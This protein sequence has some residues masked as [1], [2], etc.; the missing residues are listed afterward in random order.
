MRLRHAVSLTAAGVLA[1]LCSKTAV[2]QSAPAA[3]P[4]TRIQAIETQINALQNQLQQL[5]TELGN[6]NQQLHQSQEQTKQAQDAAQKAQADAK[7]AAA[8][9]PLISFPNG[10]P[11]ISSPD[12]TASLAIGTQVQFDMGG[13]FQ[14]SN[15]DDIQPPGARELNTGSNLRRARLFVV[16]KYYDWTVNL[17]PDFGGSPDGTVSLYEANINTPSSRS[18]RRSASSSHGTA[19]RIR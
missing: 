12:K 1:A 2:A 14:D 3:N 15:S 8:S 17:T 4:D 6:T 13:Y 7:T 16:G 19:S 5:K 18:P 9:T 11:T 10:R